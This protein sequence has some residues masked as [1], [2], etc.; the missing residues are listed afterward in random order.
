MNLGFSKVLSRPIPISALLVISVASSRLASIPISN[1]KV[2]II[3][4]VKIIFI[5]RAKWLLIKEYNILLRSQN[6]I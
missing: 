4:K 1:S 6:I 2:L 5:S 3:Y